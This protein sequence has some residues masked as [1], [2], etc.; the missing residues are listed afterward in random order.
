MGTGQSIYSEKE[1]TYRKA[2][3]KK[4]KFFPKDI[5]KSGIKPYLDYSECDKATNMGENCHR[6]SVYES[7]DEK[8]E[9]QTMSCTDYCGTHCE[10]W[11]HKLFLSENIPKYIKTKSGKK[12]AIKQIDLAFE[13]RVEENE[14]RLEYT[15]KPFTFNIITR[16]NTGEKKSD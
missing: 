3:G 15:I 10:K 8:G 16:D 4:D 2:F 13:G 7:K 12:Y 6:T 1:L 14:E 11:V 9:I 5:W